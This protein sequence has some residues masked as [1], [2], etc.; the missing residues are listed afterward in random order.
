MEKW[1]EKMTKTREEMIALGL[2]DGREE[3]GAKVIQDTITEQGRWTTLHDLIFQLPDM[4]D[5]LAYRTYYREGST[6]QQ[7]EE[8]WEYQPADCTLVRRVPKVVDDWTDAPPNQ[9]PDLRAAAGRRVRDFLPYGQD[10]AHLSHMCADNMTPEWHQRLQDN[11]GK[12]V[13]V[14]R[15][16][17]YEGDNTAVLQALAQSLPVGKTFGRP[18]S[19]TTVVEEVEY[20]PVVEPAKQ[21]EAPHPNPFGLYLKHVPAGVQDVL[22]L[23]GAEITQAWDLYINDDGAPVAGA[24]DIGVYVGRLLLDCAAR[25]HSMNYL[26]LVSA[27][28]EITAH[29]AHGGE[30]KPS[31]QKRIHVADLDPDDLIGI[32]PCDDGSEG[33]VVMQ[34]VGLSNPE[35]VGDEHGQIVY[36]NIMD[37]AEVLKTGKVWKHD[38]GEDAPEE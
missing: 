15:M 27:V 10:L 29:F 1:S 16:T 13:R 32:A 21:I 8:P 24:V 18:E 7:D 38:M 17:T 11:A 34:Q 3:G 33:W 22:A 36:F 20:G 14:R 19:Y 28:A 2:P 12:R 4:P 9:I 25:R 5:D 26:D 35:P 6:E 37:A 31:E 30:S 23:Y